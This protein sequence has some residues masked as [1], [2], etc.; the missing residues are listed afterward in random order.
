MA[1]AVYPAAKTRLLSPGINLATADL[2]MIGVTVSSG[3]T[4]YAFSAAHD[5]LDDVAS[6]AIIAPAV[7]L[8]N[9]A[10]ANGGLTADPLVFPAVAIDG[11]KKIDALI[12]YLHT[13]TPSTSALLA[14]LDTQTGLPATPTGEDVTVTWTGNVLTQS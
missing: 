8:T 9:K 3:T 7:A 12:L 14:Y 13:G 6:G 2:R 4:N 10:V 5:F 1:N 11:S